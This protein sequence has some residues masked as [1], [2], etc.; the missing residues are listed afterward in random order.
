MKCFN[1]AKKEAVG[2]C[3]RCGKALCDDCR[4]FI[5]GKIFCA[6]CR[7]ESFFD[8]FDFSF[9]FKD[10]GKA[11]KEWAF[12]IEKCP[13]CGKLVKNDFVICPYCQVNLKTNCKSCGRSVE[14]NWI[15]C[16]FCGKKL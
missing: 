13:Q 11:M 7:S 5:H 9:G 12:T 3:V 2:V 4:N 1:H 14:R 8:W 6:D 10:F 16:P 15:A